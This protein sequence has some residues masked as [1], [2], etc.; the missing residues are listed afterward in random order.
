VMAK[1]RERLAASKQILITNH[2]VALV[3][4]WTIL[5]GQWHKLHMERFN[6]KKLNEVELKG[7]TLYINLK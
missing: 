3:R 5:T 6:L 7:S 2:S 4:R 1:V